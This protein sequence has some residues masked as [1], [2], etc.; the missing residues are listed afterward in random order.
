MP[1]IVGHVRGHSHILPDLDE[2][3]KSHWFGRLDS[4]AKIVGIFSFVVVCALLTKVELITASLVLAVAI[5]AASGAP[6]RSL[7]K[8]YA[9]AFPFMLLASVS[10]F[11]FAGIERGLE[12]LGRTSA[13]VIAL[14]ALASGTGTFGLFAGL[15]RLR[16]PATISTLLM[17]TYRYILVVSEEF[18]RMRT[19]RKARG[20]GGGRSLLDKYALNTISFTAGTV[21]V[22]A[23]ARADRVYEALRCRGFSGDITVWRTSSLGRSDLVFMA[24]LLL[25]SGLLAAIQT[26]WV[27]W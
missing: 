4:R 13:C 11:L 27:Q 14:L 16:V 8:A 25:S 1:M 26:G 3:S 5:A 2:H 20:F 18:F 10:V 7:A 6:V 21:L 23:T 9:A 15:R 22:R 24:V 17:L 19:A 12:M